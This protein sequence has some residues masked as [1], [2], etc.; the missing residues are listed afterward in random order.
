MYSTISYRCFS[1]LKVNLILKIGPHRP[2][3]CLKCCYRGQAGA[4]DDLLEVKAVGDLGTNVD[5]CSLLLIEY[6]PR[7][8]GERCVSKPS[9]EVSVFLKLLLDVVEGEYSGLDATS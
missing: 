8:E 9:G 5:E 1:L 6:K 3:L 7:F 2:L 4:K